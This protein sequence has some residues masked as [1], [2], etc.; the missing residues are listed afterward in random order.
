MVPLLIK[1][2]LKYVLMERGAQFVMMEETVILQML[3]VDNSATLLIVSYTFFLSVFRHSSRFLKL[4][5]LYVFAGYYPEAQIYGS[6]TGSIFL[7]DVQCL[8]NE[9]NLLACSY[10]RP[11]GSHNCGHSEDIG[12]HCLIGSF[13]YIFIVL[14]T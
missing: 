2:V 13:H 5:I 6:G 12:V 3:C 11:I 9:C 10:R 1:D 14:Y 8:G 7:D 4:H